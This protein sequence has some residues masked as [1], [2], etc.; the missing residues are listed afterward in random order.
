MLNGHLFAGGAAATRGDQAQS[1]DQHYYP[2]RYNHH[3]HHQPPQLDQQAAGA[4][5]LIYASALVSA[6]LL[7]VQLGALAYQRAHTRRLLAS[8]P[9]QPPPSLLVANRR[10]P[11]KLEPS[12]NQLRA[13]RHRKLRV[14]AHLLVQLLAVQLLVVL[15]VESQNYFLRR[16]SA[17]NLLLA[18]MH[19]QPE[20]ATEP[21]GAPTWT[22]VLAL[23]YLIASITCWLAVKLTWLNL[24]LA[25]QCLRGACSRLLCAPLGECPGAGLD[26]RSPVSSGSLSRA[27][28]AADGSSGAPSLDGCDKQYGIA[29]N[30]S[31]GTP[32]T[33]NAISTSSIY[34]P[35]QQQQQQQAFQVGAGRSAAELQ[36]LQSSISP[37]SSF[38]SSSVL[39]DT[40]QRHSGRLGAGLRAL[41][42]RLAHLSLVHLLPVLLAGLIGWLS[43]ARAAK[44][45]NQLYT[46]QASPMSQLACWPLLVDASWP[47]LAGLIYYGPSVSI[48]GRVQ[49]CTLQLLSEGQAY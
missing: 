46:S 39:G 42:S 9:A 5:W 6:V 4:H 7:V 15:L 19:E 12:A 37:S 29:T 41:A 49:I 18:E 34:A 25:P 1:D 8:M 24:S 2:A 28:L 11:A 31:A 23:Y 13:S 20:V 45:N 35:N 36:R 48:S 33:G 16:S 17:R 32:A 14:P 26:Q 30:S 21:I 27:A 47:Y 38:A 44:L 22:A 10:Q 43:S 40:N 3:H